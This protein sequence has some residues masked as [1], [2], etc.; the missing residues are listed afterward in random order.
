MLILRPEL[1]ARRW[2][3]GLRLLT[4]AFLLFSVSIGAEELDGVWSGVQTLGGRQGRMTLTI[5][6]HGQGY[7]AEYQGLPSFSGPLLNVR[8]G[9]GKQPDTTIFSAVSKSVAIS[10]GNNARLRFRLMKELSKPML[11]GFVHLDL[12]F[13]KDVDYRILLEQ[14]PCCHPGCILRDGCP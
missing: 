9:P 2:L 6:R 14:R 5:R 1:V 11:M 12:D 7:A 8:L 4:L 10:S 3:L 13:G